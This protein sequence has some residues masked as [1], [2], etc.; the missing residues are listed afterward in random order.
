MCAAGADVERVKKGE[1]DLLELILLVLLVGVGWAILQAV[2]GTT[3]K[4]ASG[5]G[6]GWG[7]IGAGVREIVRGGQQLLAEPALKHSVALLGSA[8]GVPWLVE[9]CRLCN[10][11][12]SDFQVR[13]LHLML[14]NACSECFRVNG[15]PIARLIR[16]ILALAVPDGE[17]AYDLLSAFLTAASVPKASSERPNKS[18]RFAAETDED[19][20]EALI[21]GCGCLR[22]AVRQMGGKSVRRALLQTL[23]NPPTPTCPISLDELLLPDGHLDRGVAMIVQRATPL[24][25]D[26][27]SA[28]PDHVFLF[29][30]DALER[31]FSE[32]RAPTNPLTRQNLDTSRDYIVIS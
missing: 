14:G 26:D 5:S 4:S 24:E 32:S 18:Q 9:R 11:L 22:S 10:P 28:P 19:L 17:L 15:P 3:S 16:P 2:T 8:Y 7:A 21:A 6:S 30:K 25:H 20:D 23:R 1:M 13:Q 27:D 12:L 31:W 29:R